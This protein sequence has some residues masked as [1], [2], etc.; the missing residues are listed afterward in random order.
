MEKENHKKSPL[1]FLPAP[2]LEAESSGRKITTAL[3]AQN[4]NFCREKNRGLFSLSV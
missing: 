1:P 4:R 2:R 3:Y